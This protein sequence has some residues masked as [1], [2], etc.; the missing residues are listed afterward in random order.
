MSLVLFFNSV[1]CDSSWLQNADYTSEDV[2]PV[3]TGVSSPLCF[4][5]VEWKNVNK[6]MSDC[7]SV[8]RQRCII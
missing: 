8:D 7:K 1:I 2:T 5:L 6:K 4:V 3:S